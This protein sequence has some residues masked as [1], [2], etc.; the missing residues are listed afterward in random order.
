MSRTPAELRQ[1]QSEVNDAAGVVG[2]SINIVTAQLDVEVLVATEET[3]REF[4]ERYGAGTVRLI[5]KLEPID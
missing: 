1:V 4:A 3:R 2:S 5:G